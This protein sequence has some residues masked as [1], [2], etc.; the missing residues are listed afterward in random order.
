MNSIWKLLASNRKTLPPIQL[1]FYKK[2]VKNTEKR[3]VFFWGMLLPMV[4]HD[5]IKVSQTPRC[6]GAVITSILS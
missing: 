1:M 6:D 4:K 3:N 2:N 5:S